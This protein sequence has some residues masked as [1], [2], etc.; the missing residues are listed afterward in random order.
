MISTIKMTSK[1]KQLHK[2]CFLMGNLCNIEHLQ[3]GQKHKTLTDETKNFCKNYA[4]R[5]FLKFCTHRIVG[6]LIVNRTYCDLF[7]KENACSLIGNMSKFL[8][9]GL[10]ILQSM[11]DR[12]TLDQK[13]E[14]ES[15]EQNNSQNCTSS[16]KEK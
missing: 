5:A 16:T 8:P 11:Q 12:L 14:Q 10:E 6:H 13:N 1:T 3:L 15:M 9:K 7:L 2:I 4:K